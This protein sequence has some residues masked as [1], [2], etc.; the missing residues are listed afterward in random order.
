MSISGYEISSPPAK[1]LG[2]NVDGVKK[3]L[4]RGIFLYLSIRRID[5][6]QAKAKPHPWFTKPRTA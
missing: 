6:V 2:S 1:S 5:R 4:T 3:N